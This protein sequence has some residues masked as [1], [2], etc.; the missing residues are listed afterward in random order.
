MFQSDPLVFDHSSMFFTG[1]LFQSDLLTQKNPPN[2]FSLSVGTARLAAGNSNLTPPL[3]ANPLASS[4]L[5]TM[6]SRPHWSKTLKVVGF[7]LYFE[8]MRFIFFVNTGSKT[9]HFLQHTCSFSLFYQLRAD[10]PT[11]LEF[12]KKSKKKQTRITKTFWKP[13]KPMWHSCLELF[14]FAEA[15]ETWRCDLQK[16][17]HE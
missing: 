6:C 11:S 16:D 2:R 12:S 3:L 17:G 15:Q 5:K 4:M 10:K 13:K 14:T 9:L 8:R 1:F 7:V